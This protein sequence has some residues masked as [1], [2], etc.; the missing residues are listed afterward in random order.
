MGPCAGIPRVFW[1]SGFYF[2]QAFVTSA[3][4]N[5]ARKLKLPIDIISFDFEVLSGV[6]DDSGVPEKPEAGVIISGP[7]L[8]GCR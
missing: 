2:P 4:Q 5:Y 6:Y 1:I 8:E 3:C 7:F